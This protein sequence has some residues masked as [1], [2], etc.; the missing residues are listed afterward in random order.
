MLPTPPVARI[1]THTPSQCLPSKPDPSPVASTGQ[2]QA[3]VAAAVTAALT[4]SQRMATAGP[5]ATSERVPAPLLSLTQRLLDT[6]HPHI[7][8][9][10]PP[11]PSHAVYSE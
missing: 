11:L 3:V 8:N 4:H 2:L 9:R 10:P 7:N 1:M 5:A 6:T